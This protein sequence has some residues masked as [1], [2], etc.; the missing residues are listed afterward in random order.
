MKWSAVIVAL[1]FVTSAVRAQGPDDQYVSIYNLIQEADG[2]KASG[3]S[4]E[5]ATKYREAQTALQKFQRIYPAWNPT[6]VSFR[7]GYIDDRLT[8]IS[9]PP[10]TPPT[11]AATPPAQAT[12]RPAAPRST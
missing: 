1:L 2:L 4:A 5:A 10:S 9:G 12:P 8:A 7:L 6:V 3:Q 11:T